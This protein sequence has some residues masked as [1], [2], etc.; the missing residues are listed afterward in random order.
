[1]QVKQGKLLPRLEQ[2]PNNRGLGHYVTENATVT[3][4]YSSEPIVSLYTLISFAIGCVMGIVL[5]VWNNDVYSSNVELSL[6]RRAQQPAV[7]HMSLFIEPN[8]IEA[9]RQLASKETSAVVLPA[10]LLAVEPELMN[11]SLQQQSTVA[12]KISQSQSNPLDQAVSRAI[13]LAKIQGFESAEKTLLSQYQRGNT[14]QSLLSALGALYSKHRQWKKAALSY[15][16]ACLDYAPNALCFYNLAVSYEHLKK[17]RKA[18]EAYQRA[19]SEGVSAEGI[20]TS[21]V[22][23]RI[24]ELGKW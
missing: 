10:K 23:R 4:Y 19:L 21:M 15:S 22:Q 6:L 3:I 1:M 20:A 24:Q 12:I 9:Q 8:L 5:F 18:I 14:N 13:V 17:R 7:K 16:R 2:L 11:S